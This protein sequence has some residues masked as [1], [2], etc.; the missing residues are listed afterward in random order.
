MENPDQASDTFWN[1]HYP[2]HST[3][4]RTGSKVGGIRVCEDDRKTQGPMRLRQ[5]DR[6]ILG[7]LQQD[8][9][10]TI[11][12]MA[13]IAN[14][15]R[16]TVK[17]RIDMLRERQVI[18]RFTIELAQPRKA[19]PG[20][21]SAFFLLRLKRPVC[22]IVSG[23]ISGWPELLGCWSIAGDLDMVVLI[24]ATSNREIERLRESLARHPEIKTLTTLLILRDWTDESNHRNSEMLD[25]IGC[26]GDD[27]R[28]QP[29]AV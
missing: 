26:D 16:T 28:P 12:E 10:R 24:S 15:S 4:F 11:S 23:A 29:S 20:C 21:G 18:R 22:R 9:R 7:L 27:S 17:D 14:V 13:S 6:V 1:H 8:A 25:R 5:L 3:P 2:G 19:E